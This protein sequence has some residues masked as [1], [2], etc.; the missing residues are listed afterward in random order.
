[1]RRASR[2]SAGVSAALRRG[3]QAAPRRELGGGS[4]VD[5][6]PTGQFPEGGHVVL[7]VGISLEVVFGL[8]VSTECP[9]RPGPTLECG[10]QRGHL[11]ESRVV[12][13]LGLG[14]FADLQPE[15]AEAQPGVG[16]GAVHGERV[17]VATQGHVVL[18]GGLVRARLPHELVG[19]R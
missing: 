4:P 7:P 15:R 12:D 10:P 11:G 18:V 19:G 17:G 6:Q 8:R 13:A 9:S 1:M 16:A 3:E 5:P 2:S 14:R